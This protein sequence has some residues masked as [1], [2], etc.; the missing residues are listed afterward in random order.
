ML[1]ELLVPVLPLVLVLE[2]SKEEEEDNPSVGDNYCFK[3]EVDYN[4]A[5]EE[6]DQTQW[7]KDEDSTLEDQVEQLHRNITNAVGKATVKKKRKIRNFIKTMVAWAGVVR[8][9]GMLGGCV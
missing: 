5:R 6:L 1:R 9:P 4:K 2:P 3:T 7:L 8:M